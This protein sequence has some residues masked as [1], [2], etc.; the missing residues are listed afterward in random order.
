MRTI[1][2]VAAAAFVAQ[3]ADAGIRISEWMYQG[4]NGEFIEIVNIGSTPVDLTGWSFDDD[5]RSAGT[6]DLSSLGTLAPGQAAVITEATDAAF[7]AAWGLSAGVKVFAENGT[8]LGRADEINIYDASDTLVDRLTYGDQNFAGTVRTQNKSGWN[9]PVGTTPWGNVTPSWV[10]S[11]PGDAQGSW[12]STGGDVASPGT[13]V[14]APGAFA[15]AG[16]A[17]FVAGRRNRR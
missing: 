11:A 3:S 7:R 16:L 15:L 1:L 9:S 2:A 10:L 17:T 12:T 13:Y 4:A 14:P 5:S 8:N 6:V